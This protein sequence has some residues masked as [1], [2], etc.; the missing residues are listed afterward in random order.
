MKSRD[1]NYR[2]ERDR[3]HRERCLRELLLARRGRWPGMW[4][5]PTPQERQENRYLVLIDDNEPYDRCPLC[6]ARS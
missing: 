5:I 1:Q 2:H 3:R 6:A 4:R